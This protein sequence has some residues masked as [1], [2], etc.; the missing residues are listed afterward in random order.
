M[1]LRQ[2][3]IFHAIMEAG[4]IT[5][6]A[7]AFNISQPAVTTILRHTEDQ[8]KF[9]LFNRVLGRLEPTPEARILFAETSRVFDH[10][11]TV[12]QTVED[13][14]Q[15]RLGTL[16]IATI[17]IL[18]EILLPKVIAALLGDRPKV[19]I[20]FQVRHR[21]ELLDLVASQSVDLGVGFLLPEHKRVATR[22]L[23]PGRLICIMPKDHPL[24]Q[25]R[26]ISARMLSKH[27]FIGYTMS[28]GLNAVIGAAFVRERVEIAPMIEV[29]LISNAWALVNEGPGVALVDEHSNLEALFPNVVRRPF[30]PD[31][32]IGLELLQPAERQLSVLAQEFVARLTRHVARQSTRDGELRPLERGRG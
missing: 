7:K 23:V 17:P 31:T 16:S 12:R 25:H 2:I 27:P 19:Q 20:R 10:V 1:N 22:E 32:P 15:A 3:E 5:G 9:K 24:T 29:G 6:A 11:R 21:R 26:E 13:L 28:Q 30:V 14:R 18:G 4:T 8:L